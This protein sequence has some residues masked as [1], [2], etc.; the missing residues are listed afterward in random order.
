MKTHDDHLLHLTEENDLQRIE[1]NLPMG[2]S[3][4]RPVR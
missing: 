4:D 2:Y 1:I 3:S